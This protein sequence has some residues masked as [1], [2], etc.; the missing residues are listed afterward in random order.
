MGGIIVVDFIDMK[1]PQLKKNLNQALKEAMSSDRARHTILPM[2]K[3]GLVEITRERVRPQT[4]ISNTETCPSCNGSGRIESSVQLFE[5]LENTLIYLW[6]NLNHQ[7][8]VLKA[9]P[10]IAAYISQGFPSVRLKW[11]WKYRHWLRVEAVDTFHIGEYRFE[12]RHGKEIS[13][14]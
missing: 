10:F 13:R 4:V 9:H 14:L 1:D 12:D 6:E 3:F 8:V 2:S 7:G 5:M 11:W